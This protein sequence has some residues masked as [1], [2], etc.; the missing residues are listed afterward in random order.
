VVRFPAWE[1][2][3]LHSGAF[4]EP[5][6]GHAIFLG[7]SMEVETDRVVWIIA[8][9]AILRISL[10]GLEIAENNIPSAN[11]QTTEKL[12]LMFRFQHG[13]VPEKRIARNLAEPRKGQGVTL[14][15][16][17]NRIEESKKRSTERSVTKSGTRWWKKLFEKTRSYWKN[18]R[19][20]K[21]A[22]W[23]PSAHSSDIGIDQ[24]LHP[25]VSC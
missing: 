14:E 19:R 18:S 22:T 8:I 9:L 11:A 17:R 20:S 12:L 13:F 3:P 25:T 5:E 7:R 24:E 1:L 23:T 15:W 6:A 10:K 2:N 4:E 21:S 16:S